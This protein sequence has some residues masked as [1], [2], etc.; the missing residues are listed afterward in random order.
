MYAH[1]FCTD[2]SSFLLCTCVLYL[3]LCKHAWVAS[4]WKCE[5]LHTSIFDAQCVC[6]GCL[7]REWWLK[8]ED[9]SCL[10]WR[11]KS[12]KLHYIN[13]MWIVCLQLRFFAL[14]CSRFPSPNLSPHLLG[15]I[16]H[17]SNDHNQFDRQ[18]RIDLCLHFKN[19]Q[20]KSFFCHAVITFNQHIV[21]HMLIF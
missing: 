4:K 16:C 18:L 20:R 10:E 8:N 7:D 14:F 11:W 13:H 15:F 19:F 17:L 3:F 1:A 21:A 2:L 5:M 6:D 9:A 12:N